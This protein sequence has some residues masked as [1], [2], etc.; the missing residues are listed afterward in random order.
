MMSISPSR[1]HVV[2]LGSPTTGHLLIESSSAWKQ[3]E[4]KALQDHVDNTSESASK[5]CRRR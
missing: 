4:E 1:K 3:R 2:V 5:H